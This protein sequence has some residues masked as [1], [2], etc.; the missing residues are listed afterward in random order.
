[1]ENATTFTTE[2]VTINASKEEIWDILFNRFGQ[3]H[4][5]NPNIIGS[6]DLDSRKGEVGCE[7][8]CNIDSKTFI[9][10]RI[11]AAD[12]N[13]SLVIATI[14]GNMPMMKELQAEFSIQATGSHHSKVFI[15]ALY[16]TK[17]SF[18]AFFLK[19][20]F[21]KMMF[22]VLVGLKYHLETGKKVS[23]SEYKGI[24]RSF[25][26]LKGGSAFAN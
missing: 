14:G 2:S 16:T 19:A 9:K 3:T 20:M 5:Y 1:M 7:R 15:T 6:H 13:K 12:T 23:K 17:P 21:R 10:E 4:L 11:I 22:G 8:Q 24:F 26:S 25:Q 18:M